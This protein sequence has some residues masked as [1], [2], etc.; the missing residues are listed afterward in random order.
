M[1]KQELKDFIKKEAPNAGQKGEDHDTAY[2][3]ALEVSWAKFNGL[4]KVELNKL[5]SESRDRYRL[6]GPTH[7]NTA[8][9]IMLVELLEELK[10]W[11]IK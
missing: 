11:E 7:S 3:N 5:L 6:L 2:A 10:K 1:N 8:D 9:C 4:S